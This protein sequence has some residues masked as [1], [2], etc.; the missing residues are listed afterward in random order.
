MI[1]T[2]T[3]RKGTIIPKDSD[4]EDSSEDEED[5]VDEKS[6]ENDSKHNTAAKIS[7]RSNLNSEYKTPEDREINLLAG[8]MAMSSL[9]GYVTNAV[10]KRRCLQTIQDTRTYPERDSS[11]V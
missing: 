6:K 9:P 4:D 10:N 7:S 8:G 5:G 3:A 2:W 1:E 11:N